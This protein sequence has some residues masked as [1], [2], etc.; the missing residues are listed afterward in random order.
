MS[1]WNT[2]DGGQPARSGHDTINGP[3]PTPAVDAAETLAGEVRVGLAGVGIIARLPRRCG[4]MA[5][6]CRPRRWSGRSSAAGYCCR[7]GFAPAPCPQPR[8]E[9]Q[10]NRVI[11]RFFATLKCEHLYRTPIDHGGLAVETARFRDIY[12]RVRP[13]QALD[14]RIPRR[15]TST[16][17]DASHGGTV[18]GTV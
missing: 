16:C 11:E 14:D 3:W 12:N 6:L 10:I 15:A 18:S 2:A 1:D 8:A 4:S 5:T 13:H 7:G 9:S 17:D